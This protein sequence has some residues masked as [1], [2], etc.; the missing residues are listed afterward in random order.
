M[1]TNKSEKGQHDVRRG[2]VEAF[3]EAVVVLREFRRLSEYTR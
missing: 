3:D 1:F 2:N